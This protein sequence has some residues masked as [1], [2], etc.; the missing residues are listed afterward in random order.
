MPPSG[1]IK[2]SS[3]NCAIFNVSNSKITKKWSSLAANT[4]QAALKV[5]A[6]DV[7]NFHKYTELK[8]AKDR[9]AVT[10]NNVTIDAYAA[11]DVTDEPVVIYVPALPEPRLS[12]RYNRDTK[13][14]YE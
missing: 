11:F 4:H 10:P 14:F 5:G 1:R 7:N 2:K 9:F 12:P 13:Y 3:R 6:V 8:T